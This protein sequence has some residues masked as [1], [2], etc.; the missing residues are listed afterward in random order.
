MNIKYYTGFLFAI[1]SF[2][3]MS[4]V[5]SELPMNAFIA[6]FYLALFLLIVAG[7]SFYSIAKGNSLGWIFLAV[8]FAVVL[9]DSLYLMVY[10]INRALGFGLIVISVVG[11]VMSILN[12]KPKKGKKKAK[13]TSDIVIEDIEIEKIDN[14]KTGNSKKKSKGPV[15]VALTGVKKQKGYLYFI[16]KDGDISKVKMKR[17]AKKAKK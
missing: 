15:K 14:R 17:K 7:V 6:E 4:I 16:D 11:F 12:T 13:R 8:L 10:T 5:I 1:V 9:L 2:A 3:L